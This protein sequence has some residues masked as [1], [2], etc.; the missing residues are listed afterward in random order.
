ML[1]SVLP[2]KVTFLRCMHSVSSVY[3][4]NGANT[5][6]QNVIWSVNTCL[7]VPL[8]KPS[9]NEPDQKH[10]YG[11]QTSSN[12]TPAGTHRWWWWQWESRGTTQKMTT[13]EFDSRCPL[14]RIHPGWM[15]RSAFGTLLAPWIHSASRF[16]GQQSIATNHLNIWYE[17]W[18][19]H[20]NWKW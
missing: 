6:V 2:A 3:R 18:S 11:V 14:Y 17:T 1:C 10:C 19:I 9:R 8:H 16:P 4:N 15:W 20:G 7:A 5:A 12:L 13:S